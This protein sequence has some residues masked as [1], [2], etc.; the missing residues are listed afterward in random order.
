MRRGCTIS[1]FDFEEKKGA[2][3][4][5]DSLKEGLSCKKPLREP[6]EGLPSRENSTDYHT[7]QTGD[8]E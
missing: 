4:D 1:P 5:G 8:K 2:V 3:G 6:W 7:L